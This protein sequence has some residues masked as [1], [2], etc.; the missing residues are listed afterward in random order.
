MQTHANMMLVPTVLP[1]IL[2]IVSRWQN[3]CGCS[4]IGS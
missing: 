2:H 4:I 1:E 3:I